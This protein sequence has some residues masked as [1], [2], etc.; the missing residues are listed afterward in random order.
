MPR[1]ANETKQS[2]FRLATDTL[3]HLDQIAAWL[4]ETTGL[5]ATRANA[6]RWA[7][8]EGAKKISKK[9]QKQG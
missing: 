5:P 4:R 2:Q 8:Q 9:I 1:T 7:A 3:D 6:V